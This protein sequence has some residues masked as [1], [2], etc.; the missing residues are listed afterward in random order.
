M[1]RTRQLGSLPGRGRPSLFVR[2]RRWLRTWLAADLDADSQR[3]RKG[4]IGACLYLAGAVYGAL[5]VANTPDAP[6][7]QTVIPIAVAAVALTLS[8]LPWRRIPDPVLIWP[9]LPSILFTTLGSGAANMLGHYQAIYLLAL[10]YA[11]LVLRPGQT[12]KV[13]G[14]GLSLLAVVAGFGLQRDS[15]VEITGTILASALVGEL[16]AISMAAQS[17]QRG[18]LEHLH[19][20]VRPLLSA[21]S[22]A[23]AI[24]LVSELARD[25]LGADGVLTVAAGPEAEQG[26]THTG[27]GLVAASRQPL[28]IPDAQRGPVGL[29][30][31]GSEASWASVLFVPIEAG[32]Q[33]AAVM[34]VWWLQ[35]LDRLDPFDGQVM[36]L[37]S[38][39]AGPVLMRMH[40]VAELDRAATTDPLTGV[41]NR[42]AF[43]HAMADLADDGYLVLFDLDHFKVLNDTQGHPAGDAVL[44]TFAAAL[45]NSVS[46][47]DLVCRIGGDE[48]AVLGHGDAQA[49]QR[50]LDRLSAGWN[51]PDGV[52]FS[53]GFALRRPA[54]STERLGVRADQALYAVKRRRRGPGMSVASLQV[55]S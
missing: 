16:I 12:A 54:E 37:L 44:Q 13:A 22:E 27:I 7:S 21:H 10:G 17:R 48:F 3:Q 33:L 40:Q 51:H 39:Q 1:S 53:A 23:E 5:I 49:A 24:R 55:Q 28:F 42:R 50:V 46:D 18:K 47:G 36:E 30:A 38:L 45:S 4:R 2:I 29:P 19:T 6:L 8:V 15:L 26:G 14:V 9:V 32:E 43:E 31:T 35:P 52:G 41:A 25:L 11:G 34:V 20:G